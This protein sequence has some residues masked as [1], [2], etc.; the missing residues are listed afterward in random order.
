M[1]SPPPSLLPLTGAQTGIWFDEK[2]AGDRLA[3]NMADYLDIAGPLDERLLVRALEAVCEEAACTRARF[4]EV[5]GVPVQRIDPLGELPLRTL[6]L[7]GHPE[8]VAEA[9][10]LMHDDLNEPFELVGGLLFRVLLVRVAA[11]RSLLY[12]AMHHLV[13]D[14]YSRLAVYRRL[15]EVY[16]AL[17]TGAA[18]AGKTLPGL[19]VLLRDEAEYLASPALDKDRRFW[20]GHLSS[21]GQPTTLSSRSPVPATAF[22]RH[23][24]VLDEIAAKSLRAA[25]VAAGVTWPTFAIAAAGAYTG[26]ATGAGDI[27]LTLPVTARLSATARSVPGMV[28]NYLP[29]PVRFGPRTTVSE[30]LKDTS[31]TLART[32]RHQRYPADRLRRFLGMRGDDRRPFGPFVNV[33]PQNPVIELGPC[34]ARLNNLSTGIVDDLMITVLDGAESGVELHVNGNPELYR[35]EEVLGHLH[36]FGEFLERLSTATPDA[37]VASLDLT[38]RCEHAEILASGTGSEGPVWGGVVER[39]RELAAAQPGAVAVVDDGGEASYSSLVVWADRLAGQLA[40]AGVGPASLVAVLAGPG[41]GFVGAVLAVLGAGAAWVP[42]DVT[43]PVARIA[44]LVGDAGATCVVAAPEHA[45]LAAQVVDACGGSVP[46]VETR[47]RPTGGPV[48]LEGLSGA[49]GGPDDLAYVIFTSGSTGKPKGAMVHRR[50]MVNHLQ[51]KVEDLG[52]TSRDRL[53]HNAP[54]TFDISV[55]QMLAALV[56]G[57]SV[58]VVGRET[59]A[60]PDALF[61]LTGDEDVSVLEVVPSLLRAALDHWDVT[62]GGPDVG[63]LRWLVVTGE[64]LPPDLCGRWWQRFPSVPLMNAYGPTECSDDVTHAVLRSG[65]DVGARAAIGRPVRNTRLYVLDDHLRPVPRG[66]IGELYVSGVGV[67]RGYLDDA[68]KTAATFLPDPYQDPAEGGG[69][70]MYRTGDHVVWRSDGQLE[71]VERRDHQVKVRGHRIELAEIETA[72]RALPEVTDAAVA[73]GAHPGGGTFLTAYTV[74]APGTDPAVIRSQLQQVL[75]SYMIPSQWVTMD[76]LPLTAHGKID[77]AALPQP[78]PATGAVR[79]RPPRDR[80]EETVCRAFASA[81]GR[82]PADVGIDDNF[83]ALGGDSITSIQAV[84]HAR[85]RGLTISPRQVFLHKTPAAVAAHATPVSPSPDGANPPLPDDGTGDVTPTPIIA[86]LCEDLGAIGGPAREFSQYVS[87]RVPEG[88]TR[89]GLAGLLQLLVDRHDVLRMEIAEPVPGVWTPRV[90]ER[91]AVTAGEL[92]TVVDVSHAAAEDLCH[93][94]EREAEAARGRLDPQHGVVLQAV[95]FDGGPG[96]DARLLLLAHHTVVDGVSWRIMVADLEAAW[97]A[98]RAGARPQLAPVPTSYRRWA[99]LLAEHARSGSRTAE[100]PYWLTQ[101]ESAA[102]PFGRRPLD[103]AVDTYATSGSLRLELPAEAT[104]ALLTDVP[105]AYHG[106]VN[107]VLLTALAVAVTE[108]RRRIGAPGGSELVV[109]LEG[110]GREHLAAGIDLS[111]TVGWFTSVFPVRLDIGGLDIDSLDEAAAGAT[112]HTLGTVVKR[113]KEQL[114]ALPDRGVGY[115]LLRHLNPQ[116][117]RPLGA[118]PVPAIGFNYL[119]RFQ[120]G[121]SGPWTLDGDRTVIGTGVRPDMPLRHPLA[122]TPVT[123]DHADGPRLVADWVWAEGLLTEDEVRD[124]AET[125]FRALRALVDHL[126]LPGAGGRTVSDLPLVTVGQEE[127]DEIERSAAALG[128]RE[129]ADVLPLTPLQSGMLF[130]S[131]FAAHDDGGTDPYALQVSADLEG[132]VDTGALESALQMLLGRHPALAAAFRHRETGDPLSVVY[133]GLRV[134]LRRVDLSGLLPQEQ[135]AALD[136]LA[137]RER[138]QPFDLARPPLMRWTL[139]R[140]GPRNLRLVWTLHHILVDGWSMPV[141]VRE[142][143]AGYRGEAEELP[144]A[145]P[146]RDYVEWLVAQDDEAARAAWRSALA[147]LAEPT[148]A[149]PA[150]PGRVPVPPESAVLRLTAQETAELGASASHRGLTTNT[151]FQGAWAVLL[152]RWLGRN[153]V[154]FGSVVSTRP[155]ALHGAASIVGPFLNTLPVRATMAPDEPVG[156]FL[157]RLQDEQAALRDVSH[158]GLAGMLRDNPDLAGLGE[159]FDTALVFENFPMDS[160]ATELPADADF[161]ILGAAARDARH[162]P[163]SLVVLPGQQLELRFDYAPDLFTRQDI[164]TLG[165][166]FHRLLREVTA[167]PD[168]L[169]SELHAPGDGAPHPAAPHPAAPRA[170]TVPG[171]HTPAPGV[172]AVPAGP[173]VAGQ[174]PRPPRNPAEETICR[175]FAAALGRDPADIGADDNFF[176]LGGDSITSIRVVSHAVSHGLAITPRQVLVHKT[177][178]AIAT[179]ATVA[180]EGA[181]PTTTSASAVDAPLLALSEEEMDELERELES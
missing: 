66:T 135:R 138:L 75:P 134:P 149:C 21:A 86:Q 2:L 100:L 157:T 54:V 42:L 5:D 10:R 140:L 55:W 146:F 104:T 14:G 87:V 112:G 3:Y 128:A 127:I 121:D 36:R 81:L 178:A 58:R 155:A 22:L 110:H 48:P 109:E 47:G 63:G 99:T 76:V 96:R 4:V 167:G 123:E 93:L 67:G 122:V 61:T 68:V 152:G 124:L 57:G 90:R 11:D 59:A 46:V 151:L 8:P 82:D 39:V 72:L 115:G 40:A 159:P 116:T 132:T 168:R 174:R 45:D 26:K 70:R 173:T 113:V 177:P 131:V 15:S 102:A 28:A 162:Y 62:R 105:A 91:G 69:A 16:Q 145:P 20:E 107:D 111:R 175:A 106:E 160:A 144:Y 114:R 125:W 37:S 163:L 136:G 44:G 180:D 120:V 64:A 12:L 141:L 92:I 139:V 97:S 78:G 73:A 35:D 147:G 98:T 9:L 49:V 71:F 161:R 142:L 129:V 6:D 130:Q 51:A 179:Q 17:H 53:V 52:L 23:S 103:P 7:S 165:A 38:T 1:T 108:W 24:I 85:T 143:L 56:V 27:M 158:L 88:L 77:R 50:G 41:A 171:A 30:L 176:A 118:A 148:F 25:A 84:S 126:A 29:L 153:D 181:E 150:D 60:D 164:E 65:E 89:E 95:L 43:A 117:A 172:P 83:F 133:T 31:R 154:L 170:G 19:E 74:P 166:A 137:E 101:V 32:L 156:S 13:S 33:L 18:P 80:V 169:L 79:R 94:V 119:G 34:R